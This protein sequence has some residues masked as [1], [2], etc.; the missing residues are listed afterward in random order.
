MYNILNRGKY[1]HCLG[2]YGILTGIY[3]AFCG[4]KKYSFI[5]GNKK[6]YDYFQYK[7]YLT[8]LERIWGKL[9]WIVYRAD[10]LTISFQVVLLVDYF[11]YKMS[12]YESGLDG[13][14]IDF[15]FC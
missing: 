3:S 11:M 14:T 7:K 1:E 2:R 9:M 8:D 13:T 15:L 10:I 4:M 5:T 12:F 6:K